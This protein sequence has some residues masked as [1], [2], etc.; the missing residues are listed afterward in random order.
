ME[1]PA[2]ED[3]GE[4]AQV[5]GDCESGLKHRGDLEVDGVV[6]ADDM[7]VVVVVVEEGEMVVVPRMGLDLVVCS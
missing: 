4:A 7:V 1:G 6:E 5:M 3:E 2:S